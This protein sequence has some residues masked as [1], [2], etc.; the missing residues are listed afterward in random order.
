MSL[1]GRNWHQTLLALVVALFSYVELSG[2]HSNGE[3][4]LC[5]RDDLD[6]LSCSAESLTTSS[7]CVESPGGLLVQTQLYNFN[8]GLGPHNSWTIH[9]LWPDYCNGSY[10]SS[11]DSSREY[12]N[13]PK[14]FQENKLEWL[15]RYFKI[16]WKVL[17]GTDVDLWAHEW[18]KHG[19]CMST[20]RPNCYANYEPHMEL[21]QFFT[22][23]YELYRRLPTFTFL[24]ACGILPTNETT[25]T[26]ETIETCLRAATGFVPHLGCSSDN[27]LNEIWYYFHLRGRLGDR[28]A[29][30]TGF[31][32]T[33]STFKSTCST[34]GIR[35]PHKS[36]AD[37]DQHTE[38]EE[39]FK[40]E[41]L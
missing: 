38:I 28:N 27:Y 20:L 37:I 10:P 34:E 31:Q 8:P 25:Y 6:V 2:G 29:G 21:M 7:C 23:I 4:K 15:M 11:C 9:G 12:K 5:S 3:S 40:H 39:L 18:A 13:L 30:T 33:N 14:I 26:L 19:T 36:S 1:A 16:Y 17:N 41:D 35:Y 22:T 24:S 32:G